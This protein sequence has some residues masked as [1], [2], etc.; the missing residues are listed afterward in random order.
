MRSKQERCRWKT[1][2]HA[3]A[4]LQLLRQPGGI[5]RIIPVPV[6]DVLIVV[7]YG[8]ADAAEAGVQ[9]RPRQ[10]PAF[11]LYRDRRV[12]TSFLSP[13]CC[14][15]PRR[16]FRG[17][18]SAPNVRRRFHDPRCNVIVENS[19]TLAATV[20]HKHALSLLFLFPG[21]SLDAVASSARPAV[22]RS[23]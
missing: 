20:A 10:H 11:D 22:A 3:A 21:A 1:N 23:N 18:A 4:Q 12:R 15:R 14:R 16:R 7:V 19:A 8:Q 6:E 13:P 9:N 5:L 17:E 2:L